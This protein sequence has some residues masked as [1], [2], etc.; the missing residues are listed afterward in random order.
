M[1]K[2]IASTNEGVEGPGCYNIALKHD[3]Y[4]HNQP[5]NFTFNFS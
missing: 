4:S 5:S 3:L 1:G 2:G